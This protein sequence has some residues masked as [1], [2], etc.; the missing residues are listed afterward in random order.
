[1]RVRLT[2]GAGYVGSVVKRQLMR[3][4]HELVLFDN[5]HNGHRE[6]IPPGVPLIEADVRGAGMDTS[7]TDVGSDHRK[8]MALE[9]E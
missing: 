4:G 8:R 9:T 3:A 7:P 1:M 6:K 2:G 5:L